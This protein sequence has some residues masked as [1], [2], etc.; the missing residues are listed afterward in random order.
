M[1][2]QIKVTI[3]DVTLSGYLMPDRS[4]KLDA[5]SIEAAIREVLS[6]PMPMSYVSYAVN[7]GIPINNRWNPLSGN[8]HTLVSFNETLNY[9]MFNKAIGNHKA[10]QLLTSISNCGVKLPASPRKGSVT[11]FLRLMNCDVDGE[12]LI[13]LIV[14]SLPTD[15]LSIVNEESLAELDK[16]GEIIWADSKPRSESP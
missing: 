9:W 2:P 4:V 1:L 7:F 5:L 14:R 12:K 10:A 6:D 15:S 16:R 11:G 13:R 3:E 8:F